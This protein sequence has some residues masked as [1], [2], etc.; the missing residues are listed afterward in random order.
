MKECHILDIEQAAMD[1]LQALR[2][3]KKMS[4]AELGR[5]AF[6]ESTNSLAKINAMWNMKT[7]KERPLRLRMGDFFAMCSALGKEPPSAIFEIWENAK[8]KG[9]IE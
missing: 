4:Q 8:R 9:Q 6:P 2:K 3:E 7:N 5:L 1:Y